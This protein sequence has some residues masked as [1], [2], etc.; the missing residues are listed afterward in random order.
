MKI[1]TRLGQIE[2]LCTGATAQ[3]VALLRVGT[4]VVQVSQVWQGVCPLNNEASSVLDENEY[5]GLLSLSRCLM[6]FRSNIRS[7][8]RFSNLPKDVQFQFLPP[9]L[10][11]IV[12]NVLPRSKTGTC[13]YLNENA[14][15]AGRSVH[16]A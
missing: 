16:T 11:K 6:D 9:A 13:R 15:C 12:E 2:G 5:P 4:S 1:N 8:K 14:R 10:R 3:L 7:K